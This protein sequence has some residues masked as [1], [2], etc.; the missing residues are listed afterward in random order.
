[1]DCGSLLPLFR[2]MLARASLLAL[3]GDWTLSGSPPVS[4][5]SAAQRHGVVC[6][7]FLEASFRCFVPH[8]RILGT[9]R[10]VG[11]FGNR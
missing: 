2:W 8:S 6:G 11:A 4:G 7:K 1:M 5:G 3:S 9:K 10:A